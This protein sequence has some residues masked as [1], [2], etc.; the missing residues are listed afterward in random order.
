[1]NAP[2]VLSPHALPGALAPQSAG[3]LPEDAAQSLLAILG[4]D[5][6][7]LWLYGSA[8]L[9]CWNPRRSDLNLMAVVERPLEAGEKQ[10]VLETMEGLWPQAPGGGLEISVVLR[11]VAADPFS[12]TPYELYYS[13][14]WRADWRNAP[15]LLCNGNLKTDRELPV[16]LA[17]VRA[18]GIPLAGPPAG[19]VFRP[20]EGQMFLESALVTLE[21]APDHLVL[22][23]TSVIL[24]LCRTLAYVREGHF[25]S[26][27]AGGRWAAGYLPQWKW[28]ICRALEDYGGRYRYTFPPQDGQAFCACLLEELHAAQ[29]LPLAPL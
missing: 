3:T 13:A 12:P 22:E 20:V 8:A 21:H 10:A 23:P 29:G 4:T 6:T 7:G 25:F 26:K 18:S 11:E 2:A 15:R 14:G 9:G 17:S 19:E 16:R 5:L 28:L 1:M 27:A 24:N